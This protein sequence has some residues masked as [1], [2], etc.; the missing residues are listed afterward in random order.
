M[1][2][3]RTSLGCIFTIASISGMGPISAFAADTDYGLD[4]S[5]ERGHQVFND[6][7]ANLDTVSLQPYLQVDNWSFSLDIPWQRATGDQFVNN[8]F[9]PTPKYLTK[10][11]SNCDKFAAAK[12][13]QKQW[14][15][16]KYPSIANTLN[17]QCQ[18]STQT[19]NE[20]SGLS[21]VTAFV[22]YGM[23]L[24]AQGI[25]VG[26]IGVGYK[27]DNGDV[28][29]GLGSGTSDAKLE[30]SLSATFGKFTG[31]VL[32][33]Y[34]TVLGGDEADFVDNYAYASVDLAVHPLNWLTLGANW[35]YQQAYVSFADDVQSVSAYVGVKPL[36]NLRLRVYYRTYLDLDN[37]PDHEV[38]GGVTYSF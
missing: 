14:L 36:D 16:K 26:S 38:G 18:P 25:W 34:D 6:S 3:R 17:T 22:H 8:N 20:V 5:A 19:D 28:D 13:A 2:M 21:D 23:P 10:I 12:P 37:Y 33:G 4:I 32:A 7:S 1:N 11:L 15:A 24:D 29:N 31:T 35:D 30:G 27:A 9:Q